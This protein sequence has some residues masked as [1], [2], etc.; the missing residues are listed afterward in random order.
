MIQEAGP[1]RIPSGGALQRTVIDQLGRRVV[2]GHWP[3]GT[4]LRMDELAAEIGISRSVMR[5]AIGALTT[6]GLVHSRKR[7]GTKVLGATSWNAFSPDVIGWRLDDPAQRDEQFRSLVELRSA[8]EPQ[9]ARLAAL[10]ADRE[11][12][13]E[14]VGL[15]TD[16]VTALESGDMDELVRADL[17]FHLLLLRGSGNALFAGLGQIL[18]EILSG[19]HRPE[20]MPIRPDEQATRRH[21]DLARAIAAQDPDSAMTACLDIVNRSAEELHARL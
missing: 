4:L 17:V 14:M 9:A 10:R 15:A 19:K 11:L 6:L 12:S 20:L 21:L 3:P 8:V 18:T 16:M 2:S 5:E 13:T 7:R 1:A